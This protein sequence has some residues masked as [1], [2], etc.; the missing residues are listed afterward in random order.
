MIPSFPD[1]SL[2]LSCCSC[3]IS[4][5]SF[6]RYKVALSSSRYT[7]QPISGRPPAADHPIRISAPDEP[8]H[9]PARISG[10]PGI[11]QEFRCRCSFRRTRNRLRILL[12]HLL[13][14]RPPCRYP[15]AWLKN[16]LYCGCLL[17]SHGCQFPNLVDPGSWISSSALFP[18]NVVSESENH[19]LSQHRQEGSLLPDSLGS[20]K[21]RHIIELHAPTTPSTRQA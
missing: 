4:S 19:S 15:R 20:C 13:R 21:D 10:F 2:W 7:P 1:A 6:E 9:P 5:I 17:L 18:S 12:G 3:A 8:L 11:L 16:L 14:I